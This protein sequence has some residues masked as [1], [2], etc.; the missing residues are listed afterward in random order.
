VWHSS[1]EPLFLHA[2]YLLNL[3]AS[4]DP[5][6]LRSIL[7]LSDELRQAQRLGAHYVIIHAGNRKTSSV[8]AACRRVSQGITKAFQKVVNPVKILVEN[9]AGQG[10]EIG[11]TFSQLKKILDPIQEHDR[12]GICLDTAHAFA[13]GYDFSTTNSLDKLGEELDATIGFGRVGAIHLNDTRSPC[14]S[15]VDRHWHIGKGE[16]GRSGFRNIINYQAFKNL[17]GI[18]ETPRKSRADDIRNMRMLKR[19]QRQ[20]K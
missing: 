1:I 3:A 14:G 5:L 10:T 4:D 9:T 11:F 19:L 12:V 20:P 2:P 7:N 8:D 15:K 6:Y 13:A 17:P 18:M 16:I